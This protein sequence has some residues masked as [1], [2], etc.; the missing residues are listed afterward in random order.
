M[1]EPVKRG[2]PPLV[3]VINDQEWSTRSLDTILGPNGYAVLRAYTGAKGVERARS[4]HPDMVIVDANLPDMDGLDVCRELRESGTIG[5]T[6]PLV[7]MTT[8]H[9]TRQ[10][11]LDALRAGAWEYLGH[12]IDAEELLLRFDTYTRAKQEADHARS[13]GL[14]DHITGLYNVH[15]LARRARE[16]GS[17]A[18][19]Q[20]GPLACVVLTPELSDDGGRALSE[21]EL[22][23]LT[24]R[25]ADVLRGTGRLSD[26]IGRVGEAEFA[27]FAPGTDAQGAEG[28]ARRIAERVETEHGGKVRLRAGYHAVRD[29]REAS[30]EPVDLLRRA[31]SALHARPS[32]GVAADDASAWIQG[33]DAAVSAS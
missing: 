7:M 31:S 14:L 22:Q 27:V 26:A 21:S 3:L 30:I 13:E 6:T 9:P 16:L 12:P 17:Q 1:S 33:F 5:A 4:A 18:F 20:H 2:R 19:R 24:S 10:Q 11:R 25:I 8:G 28:L 29:F 15:G 23:E 32:G